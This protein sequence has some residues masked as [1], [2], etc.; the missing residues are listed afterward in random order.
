MTN[1]EAVKVFKNLTTNV[2]KVGGRGSGKATAVL[3]FEEAI[4]KAIKALNMRTPKLPLYN[5]RIYG[6]PYCDMIVAED[7]DQNKPLYCSNCGQC[8][9]WDL[10]KI[11]GEI[12]HCGDCK[13]LMFSDCYGECSKAYK[14]I[15]NPDDWCPFGELKD[16]YK[17]S[18]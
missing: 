18:N 12:V 5:G 6:C 1:K 7:K 15:V 14:G 2:F 11:K 3:K 17:N 4:Q 9:E 13:H 16:R 8:L 10:E